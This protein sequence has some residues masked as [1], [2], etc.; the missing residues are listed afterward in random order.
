MERDAEKHTTL[1]ILN[2]HHVIYL[3]PILNFLAL[4]LSIILCLLLFRAI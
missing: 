2:P 4:L 1:E 3:T